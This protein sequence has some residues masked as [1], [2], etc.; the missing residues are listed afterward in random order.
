MEFIRDKRFGTRYLIRNIVKMVPLGVA[1]GFLWRDWDRL[2]A[3][4]WLGSAS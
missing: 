3:Q 4:F 1:L 2:D